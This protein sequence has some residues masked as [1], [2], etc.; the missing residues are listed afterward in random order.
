VGTRQRPID[1]QQP[2]PPQP[3]AQ[4]RQ[5]R[6][7]PQ[8]LPQPR[9]SCSPRLEAVGVELAAAQRGVFVGRGLCWVSTRIARVWLQVVDCGNTTWA[10][11]A[12]A[13]PPLAQC[14]LGRFPRLDPE[15]PSPAIAATPILVLANEYG[16]VISHGCL[17]STTESNRRL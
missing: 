6:Q 15:S 5:P 2:Q 8:P 12:R 7:P 11:A 1:K 13:L 10:P 9:A 16:G 4:P 17:D 14:L 3:L